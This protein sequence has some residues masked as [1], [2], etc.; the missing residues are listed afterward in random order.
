M[1]PD[2]AE[3][4]RAA[5]P[6]AVRFTADRWRDTDQIADNLQWVTEPALAY[7]DLDQ[8]LREMLHRVTRTLHTD[9][10][11]V[12]LLEPDGET[13]AARAA[14]G[15]EEEVRRGFRLPVGRGFAGRVAATRRAVVIE[16][17]DSSPIEVVN[18]LFREK[19]VRSLLGVPLVVEARL[20]GVLHVGSLELRSF[21]QDD[22]HLLQ[23]VADRVALAIDHGRLSD[24]HRVAETLQRS[25]LPRSLPALPGYE[26]AGRYLPA[27]R[28]SAVGGDWYDVIDLG[29]NQIALAIGDVAGRGPIAA[30]VMGE[31]RSAVRAYAIEEPSPAG[32]VAR[33]SQ[34][35][36]RHES[37]MATLVYATMDLEAGRIRYARAG[38]PYPLLVDAQGKA[39]YLTDPGGPPLSATGANRY[40]EAELVLAR[41]EALFLYTDGLIERRGR[42][43]TD[44][45]ELLAAALER[46]PA[47][48]GA[49]CT[50]VI[51]EMTERDE[52]PD[53]IAV[54][55]VRNSGL[56][57]R[58]AF[59][60]GTRP[61][62]LVR[63]RGLLRRWLAQAGANDDDIDAITLAAS[64]ACA[65]AI[66]HAYGPGDARIAVEASSDRDAAVIEIRDHGRWREPRGASRGRGIPLMR[67]FM[68][69]VE[70]DRGGEGTAVRLRRRIG[71][72]R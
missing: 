41:D 11:A 26:F 9:T 20:I 14:K 53:D 55:I 54:L 70:I 34:F 15:L 12:L 2:Q 8:L 31:I 19:G 68:D 51:D 42:R 4:A 6:D 61:D 28:E 69:D 44:Q 17:L 52:H 37:P 5:D 71:G 56:G 29:A 50:A 47:D 27:A 40:G 45:E 30:T 10:S 65:N 33:V 3:G 46:A 39:T 72:G 36:A 21:D 67:E 38:H 64:E 43:L 35:V 32:V 22:I 63:V 25:L 49:I 62:E 57:D 16:D 48:A 1:S 23:T 24:Q 59:E 13:L 18:P 58:I 66:E 7:L 60:I